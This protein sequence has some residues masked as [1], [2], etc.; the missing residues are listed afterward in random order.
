MSIVIGLDLSLTATGLAEIEDGNVVTTY[1]VRSTGRKGDTLVDRSKRLTGLAHEITEWWYEGDEPDLAVVESPAYGAKYGSPHD[2]SGLWWMVVRNLIGMGIPVA[3]VAPMSRAKY[4]TGRGNAKKADVLE[5][6]RSHYGPHV[7]CEYGI[8]DDN[9]ADAILLAA[10]GARL[11]GEPASCE[12]DLEPS[13]L[14]ALDKV[15][16]PEGV[17]R[18]APS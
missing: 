10:M 16:W 18:V 11:L 8:P 4:G 5:A 1:R 15:E 14:S 13:K 17:E 7:Q 12:G 9:V 2:R 3:T 6:V